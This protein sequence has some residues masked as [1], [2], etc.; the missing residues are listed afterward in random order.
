MSLSKWALLRFGAKSTF[1]PRAASTAS[2]LGGGPAAR[3]LSITA[4]A[5]SSSETEIDEPQ[6]ERRR[7]REMLRSS[8]LRESIYPSA[9]PGKAGGILRGETKGGVCVSG[10]SYIYI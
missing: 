5:V 7:A 3:A 10:D 2:G 8:L 9:K 1:A 4:R 6:L